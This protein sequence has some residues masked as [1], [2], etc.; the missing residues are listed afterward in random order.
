[1][2]KKKRI[3]CLFLTFALTLG[4]MPAMAF[5][6][7]QE[8]KCSHIHDE[9]CGYQEEQAEIPCDQNCAD[10]DGDSI[11]DH[12]AQCS[13]TPAVEAHPCGHVH[14]ETCGGL[15]T[16]DDNGEEPNETELT[17]PCAVTEGCILEDGHA[18]DCV[19]ENED[20]FEDDNSANVTKQDLENII[21]QTQ[22]NSA[23]ASGVKYSLDNDGNGGYILTFSGEGEIQDY[24]DHHNSKEWY[25]YR[26]KITKIVVEEGITYIGDYALSE[27]AATELVLPSTVEEISDLAFYA[28]NQPYNCLE[29]IMIPEENQYY[30]IED[31]ILFT[32]D[33]SV[34][35]KAP[36]KFKT[37]ATE[38]TLPDTVERIEICAFTNSTL[39]KI[40]LDNNNLKEIGRY[41]FYDSHLEEVYIPDTV[42]EMGWSCFC[43][44]YNPLKV[45]IG[46]GLK[47]LTHQ[48]FM[49]S[50]VYEVTFDEPSSVTYLDQTSLNISDLGA[51]NIDKYI[52]LPSTVEKLGIDAVTVRGGSSAH[53]I[54]I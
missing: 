12:T 49:V 9:N 53:L 17:I 54:L 23:K 5:A 16:D 31:E 36:V 15:P 32:K 48:A 46:K 1:M 27:T 20:I 11:A 43:G 30:K 14:D 13:Y 40:D 28:T 35:V 52:E 2:K 47:E 8:S 42:T 4:A 51:E 44:I 19:L 3:L 41:A 26:D 10:T 25:S 39:K 18:G 24:P 34:L 21:P 50:G 37:G 38:Y 6:E 33:G 22:A 45:R 7:E 29:S